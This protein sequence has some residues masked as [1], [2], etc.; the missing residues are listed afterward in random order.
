MK[1][2]I[3]QGAF[4]PVPPSKGG[5][6]EAAW[7]S[8]GRKF[9]SKGHEVTHYSCMD[10][11]LPETETDG[12]VKYIRIQ[13]ATSV[14]N[15]YLLKLL[16]LPYVLRARK[17]MTGADIL[18]THAFWAPILFP[19]SN[20]GKLYVHVGRYP[21]GQ[22]GL[23][24][25]A[26]R[27]QVPSKSIENVSKEQVPA[28]A[29]KV[30]TLPYPLTWHPSQKENLNHKEKILLY[31]GR[32]H[33][34]KGVESLLQAWGKLSNE[35]A[36]GWTLRIIGPWK[37]EQ[38]GGGKKFR[39]RLV[40]ITKTSQN[41]VEF[42]EPVFDRDVLKKEMERAIFF[43]YPSEAKDGETFGLA[44]LEAM[45]CGCIPIVSDLPC[46]A[47]FISFEEEGF[48]LKQ[49]VNM[50]MEDA[51]REALPKILVLNE[52]QTSKLGLSAWNRSKE[53]ELDKVTQNYLDDF[54]SL[55]QK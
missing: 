44:V 28:Q 29:F 47:D 25:K 16:E 19:K 34:E 46:F 9:A 37:E 33:P 31:A 30:K 54:N 35:V 55:L 23:Y 3:L 26:G 53:Y 4:L 42:L 43:L 27:F 5:A 17:V 10:K 7:Y 2:N 22:L 6:I 40:K 39:D 48:C 11:G 52:S 32:I 45:S 38:G 12:G 13:G 14:S 24:K 8:L 15:P 1:I 36:R 50:N 18:V 41:Q 20:Y 51:I 21:K 49:E